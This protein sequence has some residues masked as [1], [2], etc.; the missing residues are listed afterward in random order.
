MSDATEAVAEAITMNKRLAARHLVHVEELD[1]EIAALKREREAADADRAA[2]IDERL[3]AATTELAAAKLDYKAALAELAELDRLRGKAQAA[4]A[5]S[6]VAD[7]QGDPVVRSAEQIALDNVREHAAD[8][9]AHLKLAEELGEKPPAPAP[10]PSA[11]EA[12]EAARREFE[13]LRSKPK[14]T[15]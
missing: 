7:I 3:A 9:D 4:D 12:D 8:L 6:I 13:A 10:K 15:L 14:K 2:Q 11:E 5:R 1:A